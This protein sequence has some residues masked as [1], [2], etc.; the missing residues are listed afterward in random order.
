MYIALIGLELEELGACHILEFLQKGLEMGLSARTLKGQVSAIAT[1]MG[2]QWASNKFFKA[3]V[4]LSPP[5]AL[6]KW[7]L[8][9]V[10]NFLASSR[11][12]QGAL[13]WDIMLKTS[14][15]I[16]ITLARSL[17]NCGSGG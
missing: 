12:G 8:L 5:R 9:L 1:F 11:F 16:T 6:S 17:R 3:I 2:I 15:L 10:L 14:F 7:N 4:K 13:L